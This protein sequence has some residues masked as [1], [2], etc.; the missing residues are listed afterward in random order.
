M[1]VHI[2][3]AGTYV[4]TSGCRTHE[5][6][7][8]EHT[9]TLGKGTATFAT[10]I[11]ILCTNARGRNPYGRWWARQE[12]QVRFH[13]RFSPARKGKCSARTVSFEKSRKERRCKVGVVVVHTQFPTR[14]GETD[15][16]FRV[17]AG[18]M[19]SG[20]ESRNPG[21]RIPRIRDYAFREITF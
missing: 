2:G 16:V 8:G 9:R 18:Q 3:G 15:L 1:V 5:R 4:P 7:H 13:T 20:G 11:D 21:L 12:T 17:V 19:H 6:C 10:Q 14:G